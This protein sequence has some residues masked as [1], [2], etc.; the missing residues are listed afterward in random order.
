M[1]SE[2]CSGSILSRANKPVRPPTRVPAPLD[3]YACATAAL[4]DVR[5]VHGVDE[6]AVEDAV[7]AFQQEVSRFNTTHRLHEYNIPIGGS[8]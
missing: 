1:I 4:R 7:T 8:R 2:E 3:S 5:T 6:R